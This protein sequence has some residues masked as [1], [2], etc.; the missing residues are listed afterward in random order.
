MTLEA[1]ASATD[2][3]AEPLTNGANGDYEHL[4][5]FPQQPKEDLDSTVEYIVQDD[6]PIILDS[7]RCV[8]C[9][10]SHGS[11]FELR[12]HFEFEHPE[13]DLTYRE[14]SLGPEI[15]LSYRPESLSLSSGRREA[16]VPLP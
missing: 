2:S 5:H 12:G 10:K 6:H 1:Y 7:Y 15:R 9:G 4:G 8:K 11:E 16:F 3:S 13:L 14:T